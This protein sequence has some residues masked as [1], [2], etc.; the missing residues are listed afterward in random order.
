M[1]INE[2]QL[3]MKDVLTFDSFHTCPIGKGV[4]CPLLLSFTRGVYLFQARLEMG[5]VWIPRGPSFFVLEF[6]VTHLQGGIPPN[7]DPKNSG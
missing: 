6:F 4:F 1:K 5:S 7:H 3:Y 2:N